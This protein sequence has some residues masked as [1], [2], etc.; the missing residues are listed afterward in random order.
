MLETIDGGGDN[1]ELDES[2]PLFNLDDNKDDEEDDDFECRLVSCIFL[3]C[4][5]RTGTELSHSIFFWL[6]FK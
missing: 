1:D 3:I 6:K 5:A 4:V 2:D